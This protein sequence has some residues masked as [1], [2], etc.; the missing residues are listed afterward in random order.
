MNSS[1]IFEWHFTLRGP[2]DTEFEGGLYHG[3]I[4]LPNNYPFAPP[5]LMFLTLESQLEVATADYEGLNGLLREEL[6]GFFY[7]RT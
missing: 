1:D 2:E 6:P 3:R 5:S 7:Y 4:L